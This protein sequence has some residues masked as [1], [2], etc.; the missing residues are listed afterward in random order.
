MPNREDEFGDNSPHKIEF[1][2]T[3]TNNFQQTNMISNKNSVAIYFA[4]LSSLPSL[5]ESALRVS[6]PS[7]C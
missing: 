4:L 7:L 2:T 6:L 3:A 1:R 5:V